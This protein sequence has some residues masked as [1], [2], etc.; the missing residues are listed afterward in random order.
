MTVP[1]YERIPTTQQQ[2][3]Q[4]QRVFDNLR[5]ISDR[6]EMMISFSYWF[7]LFS[8][9]FLSLVVIIAY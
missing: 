7:A 4:K 9:G 3:Q 1:K 8:A 6:P 5:R 2:Q